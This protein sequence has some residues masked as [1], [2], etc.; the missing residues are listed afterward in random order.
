MLLGLSY[1]R[2]RAPSPPILG[3]VPLHGRGPSSADRPGCWARR[4]AP[5][6]ALGLSAKF[7]LGAVSVYL[8]SGAVCTL[9]A[10][11][12]NRWIERR[13]SLKVPSPTASGAVGGAGLL[14]LFFGP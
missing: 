3:P 7:G 12:I 2:P 9:A 4:F 6:V 1:G 5:L 11:R 8:L 14:G 10:L 13:G